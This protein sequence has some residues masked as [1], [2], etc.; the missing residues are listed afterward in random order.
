MSDSDDV[1]G[2]DTALGNRDGALSDTDDGLASD[3]G[4][5]SLDSSVHLNNLLLNDVDGLHDDLLVLNLNGDFIWDL[6]LALNNFGDLAGDGVG[7][8]DLDDVS[9]ISGTCWICR[10]GTGLGTGT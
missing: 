3:V 6:D 5:S 4:G 2:N 7:S 1:G 9:M 10:T 8:G